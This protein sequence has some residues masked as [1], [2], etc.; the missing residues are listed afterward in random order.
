[1]MAWNTAIGADR[2]KQINSKCT[3]A[4]EPAG[5]AHELDERVEGK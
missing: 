3:L 1:M 2:E 5:F 4:V